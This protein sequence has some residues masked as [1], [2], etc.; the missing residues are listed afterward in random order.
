M[1]VYVTIGN[2]DDK[3]TQEEWA[4][5]YS[6]VN[7]TIRRVA[8]DIHGQWVSSPTSVYQNACWCFVLPDDGYLV[9]EVRRKL[10][11]ELKRLARE[12]RQDSIA[13]AEAE[14]ELLCD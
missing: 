2:S 14:V 1:S 9:S 13:W 8:D 10:R 6:L 11:D 7:R 4:Q 5:F 3:L 12:Y